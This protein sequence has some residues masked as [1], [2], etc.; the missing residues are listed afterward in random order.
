MQPVLAFRPVDQSTVSLSVTS[1]T[2]NV[3]LAQGASEYLVTNLGTAACF[4]RFGN[5]SITAT[6]PSGATGGSTPIPAGSV[7][8][9]RPPVT[10]PTHVAA[11]TSSGTA[12]LYVTAGEGL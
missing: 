4:F 7:Q 3:A 10:P 5:S 6:V 12:T 9:F 1:S 8:V 2:G 11:I